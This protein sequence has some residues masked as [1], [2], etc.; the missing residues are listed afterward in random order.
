VAAALKSNNLIWL[1]VLALLAGAFALAFLKGCDETT[2]RANQAVKIG[3]K[4][5]FLEV[6]ADDASRMRGLGGRTDIPPDGGMLFVFPTLQ[7]NNRGGF[8]MRDCFTDIDIIFLDSAGR[9]I[10][11]HEMKKEDPRGTYPNEGAEGEMS[12]DVYEKRLKKYPSRYPYHFVIEL[13]GGTL[14]SL[15]VKEGDKIALPIEKLKAQAK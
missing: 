4:T 14:P 2:A 9:V 3:G 12:N 15:A 11:M 1:A 10:T 8:V 5:F 7:D 13:K 6:V